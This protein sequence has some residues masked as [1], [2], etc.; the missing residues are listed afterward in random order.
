MEGVVV[1]IVASR[2][3]LGRVL[4]TP[5]ADHAMREAN[6]A[7]SS[8]LARHAGGDW[9]DLD[10]GDKALNDRALASGEDRIFSAYNIG[11]G[12]TIWIITEWDRS[13]TTFLLPS[14]Y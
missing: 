7:P 11:G 14:E 12:V 5:G 8:L 13:V 2:F 9:G 3:E 10:T 6:V 1:A 4:S